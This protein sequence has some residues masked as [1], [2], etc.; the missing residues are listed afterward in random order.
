MWWPL[1]EKPGCWERARLWGELRSWSPPMSVAC[2]GCRDSFFGCE[3]GRVV[4]V[5]GNGY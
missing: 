5:G 3:A 1:A 2:V 4:V